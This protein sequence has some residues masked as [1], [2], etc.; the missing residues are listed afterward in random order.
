MP[1]CCSCNSSGRCRNCSCVKAGRACSS[2]LPSRLSRCENASSPSLTTRTLSQ[3]APRRTDGE[4]TRQ[5][6]E[7]HTSTGPPRSTPS[8]H[9]P[10][11]QSDQ[12]AA[13]YMDVCDRTDPEAFTDLPPFNQM[14]PVSFT[15]GESMSGEDFIHAVTSAYAK[16]VHWRHNLFLLPS[17]RAGKRFTSELA[18]MFRA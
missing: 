6:T 16:L 5:T 12:A 1:I 4:V 9:L 17:G 3:P 15:W 14:T 8:W 10:D 7:V 2:C 18:R 13:P 11:T